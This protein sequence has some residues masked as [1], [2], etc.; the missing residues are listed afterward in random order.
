MMLLGE[1]SKL[2]FEPTIVGRS[3]RSSREFHS[4]VAKKCVSANV[5]ANHCEVYR[6]R[7]S[8]WRRGRSATWQERVL[9]CVEPDGP[10]VRRD[11]GVRQQHLDLTSREEHRQGGEILGFI[12]GSAEHPR[13]LQTM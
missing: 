12:L 7:C 8:L 10:R 5:G 13:R 6:R 3:D 9:L 1:T 11:G 2:Y 4:G